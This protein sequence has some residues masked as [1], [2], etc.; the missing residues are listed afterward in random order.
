MSVTLDSH[1]LEAP[2]RPGSLRGQV[3][4]YLREAIVSGRLKP[5]TRLVERDLCLRMGISRPS[6]R[7]AM[8][9]LEAE[10]LVRHLPRRGPV[11]ATISPSE[12][13]DV[14]AMRALLEGFVVREFVQLASSEAL[15]ELVAA[16]HR[17]REE[18]A[19]GDKARLLAAKSR[20]YDVLMAHCGNELVVKILRRETAR[21]S[22]LRATSLARPDRLSRSVQE[23]DA[24]VQAICRRDA[25]LAQRLAQDH[26]KQAEKVA[27]EV[28]EAHFPSS[29]D[30]DIRHEQRTL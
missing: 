21:I 3:E 1:A 15:T 5:G 24:L 8:R 9:L 29:F 22:L 20:L 11:V 13:R 7:E 25:E 23:I 4:E 27:L 17:L 14:Y 2:F 26:V 10:G 12:A 19:V 28:L 30:S 18:A 6:L 16:A